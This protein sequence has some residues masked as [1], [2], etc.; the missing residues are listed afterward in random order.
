MKVE[1]L[2]EM[3]NSQKKRQIVFDLNLIYK[4]MKLS[5]MLNLINLGNTNLNLLN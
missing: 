1:I 3:S 2:E 4:C 5:F